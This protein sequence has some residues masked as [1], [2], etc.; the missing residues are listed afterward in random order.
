MNISCKKILVHVQ[1]FLSQ[2]PPTGMTA[3]KVKH[4]CHLSLKNLHL[5][6]LDLYLIQL[7]VG[8]KY[9][10]D[11]H[12]LSYQADGT[13]AVNCVVALEEIWKAMED[14]VGTGLVR[15]IGVCNFKLEQLEK[16]VHYA[17]IKPSVVQVEL[18]AYWQQT[19]IRN[20]CKENKIVVTG[21]CPLG[22]PLNGNH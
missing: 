9:I 17:T 8:I 16:L 11:N 7:P 20:F 10:S 2:L 22:K 21:F 1:F 14:L 12:L 13:L 5:S 18:H 4:F 19:E 6:Y 3:D 15:N